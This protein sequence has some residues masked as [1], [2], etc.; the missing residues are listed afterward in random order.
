MLYITAPQ[1]LRIFC[2]CFL[3]FHFDNSISIANLRGNFRDQKLSLQMLF[4]VQAIAVE[5][6]KKRD[7][8]SRYNR[9]SDYQPSEHFMKP[10]W[11]EANAGQTTCYGGPC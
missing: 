6:R 7:L 9:S 1:S 10:F 8:K 5:N 3:R 4:R 2:R 11:A